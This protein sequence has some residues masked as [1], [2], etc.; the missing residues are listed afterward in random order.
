MEGQVSKKRKLSVEVDDKAAVA[1]VERAEKPTEDLT[2]KAKE[3]QER[4]K[5]LQARAVS[6]HNCSFSTS[7]DDE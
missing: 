3:R 6:D 1:A 5:A 7:A 4:F 2:L